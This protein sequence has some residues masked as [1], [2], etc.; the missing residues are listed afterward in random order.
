MCTDQTDCTH[1]K[2]ASDC[3]RYTALHEVSKGVLKMVRCV[4]NNLITVKACWQHISRVYVCIFFISAFNVY[5]TSTRQ[6]KFLFIYL[7]RL[8]LK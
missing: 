5:I 8:N 2:R 6:I 1:N 7:F 4:P 3:F